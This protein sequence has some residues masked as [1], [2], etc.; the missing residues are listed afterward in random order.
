MKL[1]RLKGHFLRLD[2]A[3][4]RR[5]AILQ[6]DPRHVFYT[7]MLENDTYE[8]YE[9]AVRGIEVS[10]ET[11]KNDP[12]TGHMEILYA[13]RNGWIADSETES[14]AD[15]HLG[16]ESMGKIKIPA[17]RIRQGDLVLYATSLSVREL[18]SDGFYNVEIGRA[19]V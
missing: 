13:R 18:V 11:F 3:A 14:R 17:A 19:H 15:Q 1:S 9:A 16:G 12:I 8:T 2:E 6:H 10:V 5:K 7:A 4:I